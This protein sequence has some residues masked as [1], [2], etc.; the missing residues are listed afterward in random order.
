MAQFALSSPVPA[1]SGAP[2][3]VHP[4][5]GETGTPQKTRRVHR[6]MHQT[7]VRDVP[8]HAVTADQAVRELAGAVVYDCRPRVLPVSIRLKDFQRPSVVRPAASSSLAAPPVEEA[9]VSWSSGADS[10]PGI[11]CSLVGRFWDWFGGQTVTCLSVADDY[12]ASSGLRHAPS[13]I[14]VPVSGAPCACSG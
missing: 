2:L 3:N 4:C 1:S 6:R 14:S 13:G 9:S 12:L 5:D 7:R 11:R 8:V 10:R